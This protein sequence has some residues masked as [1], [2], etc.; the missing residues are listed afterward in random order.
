MYSSECMCK[1]HVYN[2]VAK[3]KTGVTGLHDADCS[4]QTHESAPAVEKPE[5]RVFLLQEFRPWS[6]DDTNTLQGKGTG[7]RKRGALF[8]MY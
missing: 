2:Q 3:F 4:G 5:R 7:L 6:A 8:F 1:P